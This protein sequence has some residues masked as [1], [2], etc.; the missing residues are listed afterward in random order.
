MAKRRNTKTKEMVKDVLEQATTALSHEDIEQALGGQVD[1]VT[2]YRILQ[3]FEDDGFV[4]KIADE[5]GKWHYAQ[6]HACS[7]D[8]HKD[9]HIHFQCTKCHTISCLDTP[10]QEPS[11]P[12][13]YSIE[14][15]S[16]LI[17]GCCPTCQTTKS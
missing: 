16:Y 3:S 8:D 6:C 13:G 17:S 12:K 7:H 9:D 4:H 2:I 5:S 10:I 15:A 11:L 14:D 1:R